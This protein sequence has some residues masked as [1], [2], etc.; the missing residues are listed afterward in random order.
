[1]YKYY[2]SYFVFLFL[3]FFSCASSQYF[4]LDENLMGLGKKDLSEIIRIA[5]EVN[6]GICIDNIS[7]SDSYQL[8]VIV[9]YKPF[10]QTERLRKFKSLTL[11]N[12]ESEHRWKILSDSTPYSVDACPKQKTFKTLLEYPAAKIHR[13]QSDGN[14]S[15]I[16]ILEIVDFIERQLKPKESIIR[17]QNEGKYYKVETSISQEERGYYY[18][19]VKNNNNWQIILT[20]TWLS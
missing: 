1:M 12:D 13:F 9:N 19:I 14:V 11:W 2:I 18:H 16:F 15:D 7:R 10:F 4:V 5:N 6:P 20:A 17:I 8:Y 3:C